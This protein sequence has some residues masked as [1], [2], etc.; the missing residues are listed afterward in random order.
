MI[1]LV[2]RSGLWDDEDSHAVILCP[3]RAEASLFVNEKIA[4]EIQ[5][6]APMKE[7]D[8]ILREGWI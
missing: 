4:S 5:V 2:S 8:P 1:S 7:Y 3:G 6:S